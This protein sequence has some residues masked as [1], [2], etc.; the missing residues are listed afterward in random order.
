MHQDT[1][2][3][4]PN[5]HIQAAAQ[6]LATAARRVI[7]ARAEGSFS[8]HSQGQFDPAAEKLSTSREG[9]ELALPVGPRRGLM[10]DDPTGACCPRKETPKP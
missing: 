3:H 4:E 1:G 10:S 6:I 9:A 5:I 2:P 8:Q 7:A